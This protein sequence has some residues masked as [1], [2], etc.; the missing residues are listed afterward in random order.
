VSVQHRSVGPPVAPANTTDCHPQL[1]VAD[2]TAYELVNPTKASNFILGEV[3]NGELS[4][5][6][7]NLP[8]SVPRTGCPGWW[9]FAQLMDHFQD[10]GTVID[11]ILGNWTYGDNLATVNRLTGGPNALTL[12][13]AASRTVTAGYAASRQYTRAVVVSADG[14]PGQYTRVRVRFTR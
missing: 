1:N 14:R 10:A 7:E 8:R 5:V 13:E 11:A 6:V 2:P 4:F 3:D 12:E 9:L